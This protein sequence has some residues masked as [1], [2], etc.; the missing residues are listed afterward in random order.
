MYLTV[1]CNTCPKEDEDQ[2]EMYGTSNADKDFYTW[3]LSCPKCKTQI[4]ISLGREDVF[5]LVSH[6]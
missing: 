6:D 5:G 3:H 4:I 1:F 2:P